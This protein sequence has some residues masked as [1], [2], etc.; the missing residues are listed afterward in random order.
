MYTS[1]AGRRGRGQGKRRRQG[2]SKQRGLSWKPGICADM[3]TD[4]LDACTEY[5]TTTQPL[6][7]F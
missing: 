7:K 3:D 4:T 5:E 6:G 1:R 2:S